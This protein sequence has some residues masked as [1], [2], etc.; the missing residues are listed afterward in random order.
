MKPEN[1]K[2]IGKIRVEALLY[3]LEKLFGDFKKILD[4]SR[5]NELLASE[6]E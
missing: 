1:E 4:H 6:N 2:T 3:R 5:D